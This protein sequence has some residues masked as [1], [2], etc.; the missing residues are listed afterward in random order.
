M[1]KILKAIVILSI[2]TMVVTAIPEGSAGYLK[3]VQDVFTNF[4]SDIENTT[5]E[6]LGMQVN[7]EASVI[8]KANSINSDSTVESALGDLFTDNSKSPLE[9]F[10]YSAKYDNDVEKELANGLLSGRDVISIPEN[11]YTEA[12]LEY[13]FQKVIY[14]NPLIMNVDT[15]WFAD[16]TFFVNYKESE[17][18]DLEKN[19]LASVEAAKKLVAANLTE[20]M[21]ETERISAVVK[22]LFETVEYDDAAANDFVNNGYE[23][24][25]KYANAQNVYGA[26]VEN[27]AV[28]TGFA[29]SFKLIAD[30]IGIENQIVI[31][32]Y[33]GVPHIWNVVK[34][35]DKWYYIDATN[36]INQVDR[37]STYE[38][39]F[40]SRFDQDYE[41]QVVY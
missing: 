7:D 19:Q 41:V 15:Y 1:K 40:G 38:V 37:K 34:V 10:T 6:K 25:E 39:K 31:G 3:P 33:K 18:D 26:L 30:S 5:K 32:T 12:Q 28:C 20:E 13:V 4:K 36:S 24:S 16:N 21:S 2:F 17:K 22:M 8:A 35:D 29:K 11:D 23:F 9:D 14:K 27:K